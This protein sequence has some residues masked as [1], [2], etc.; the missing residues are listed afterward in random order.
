MKR[1]IF[2]SC[3]IISVIGF[4]TFGQ[5][6][7]SKSISVA[8]SYRLITANKIVSSF[9]NQ[10]YAD[11]TITNYIKFDESFVKGQDYYEY[12]IYQ[13]QS[14]IQKIYP[15]LILRINRFDKSIYVYDSVKDKMTLIDNWKEKNK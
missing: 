3:L 7:T 15:I 5:R 10:R 6:D 14:K 8:E 11:T 2:I 12:W 13:E 1:I 4:D 9:I